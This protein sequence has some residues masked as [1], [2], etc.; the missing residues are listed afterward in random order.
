MDACDLR[1]IMKNLRPAIPILLLTVS[2]Y[3]AA[4]ICTHESMHR[5]T[6]EDLIEVS[7]IKYGLFS[8]DEWKKIMADIITTKV[9]EF[10]V[11]EANKEVLR[12][13]IA[14]FLYVVLDDFEDRYYEENAKS[15]KGVLK[16]I[17]ASATSTFGHMKKDVPKFSEQIVNF[18]D[19]K[20]N[21]EALRLYIIEKL[22]DYADKTFSETDYTKYNEIL[23]KYTVNDKSTVI[24]LLDEQM[25]SIEL[26]N[27]P[28]KIALLIV[29]LLT[30]AFLLVN[31]SS[32]NIEL[33]ILCLIAF[34][35][36]VVGVLLPMIEIDARI[37]EMSLQLLGESVSFHD[38]VLYYKSKS[39]LEVVQL[40]L[41]E[42]RLDVVFVGFLV[43]CFSV[44]FPVAKLIC[45][46]LYVF[47]NSLRESRIIQFMV[48]KTG[49]WSMADVLVIAIF[50]AYIGFDGIISE[51]MDQVESMVKNLDILTTNNSSLLF[52][53]FAFTAFVLLSLFLSH[54]LQYAIQTPTKLNQGGL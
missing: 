25:S 4:S 37:Q 9:E 29:A 5:K 12:K 15:I 36:L 6:K 24:A 7:K 32:S 48:F 28:L 21:R 30:I 50:M 46:I 45:S 41:L 26:K 47:Y 10:D 1:Y 52:G 42:K 53:F 23:A 38:Q 3:L 27:D 49:K 40:M 39:I 54:K 34:V 35:F 14:D 11:D 33:L 31:R 17:V 20:K 16:N 8:V 22:D 19:E 51:Q 43:L 18:L 44:L 13:K 2:V